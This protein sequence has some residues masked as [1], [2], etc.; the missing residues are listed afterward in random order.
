MFFVWSA[1]Q[2]FALIASG[3][4][5][6]RQAAAWRAHGQEEVGHLAHIC[7]ASRLGASK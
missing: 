5:T 4:Y 7:S 6:F 3:V 2:L 1:V